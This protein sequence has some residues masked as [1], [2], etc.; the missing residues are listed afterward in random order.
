MFGGILEGADVFWLWVWGDLRARVFG[1][2]VDVFVVVD[3]E[4]LGGVMCEDYCVVAVE[5]EWRYVD[6]DHV[7]VVVE[8]F[9]GVISLY[10]CEKIVV[11]GGDD[12][13]VVVGYLVFVGV[14]EGVFL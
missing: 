11:G 2:C 6:C 5:V 13:G 14:L 8:V 9:V 4:F 7:E 3:C 12:V 10:V 1:E